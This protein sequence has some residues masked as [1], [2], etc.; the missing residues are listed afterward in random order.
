MKHHTMLIIASL[1]SILL[2]TFHL[3]DDVLREGGIA[4]KGAWNL[5]AVLILFVWLCG[6]LML[7]ERRGGTSSCSSE[8]SSG[9]ACP[10][11]T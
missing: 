11:S 8:R 2:L 10:S 7:A 5:S 3:T 6:T 9:W 4:V 1:L